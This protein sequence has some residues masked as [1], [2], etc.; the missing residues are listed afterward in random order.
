M[1]GLQ[2]RIDKGGD[3]I[4]SEQVSYVVTWEPPTGKITFPHSV[5]GG[6]K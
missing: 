5:A 2:V 4:P 3:G 6:S 1:H